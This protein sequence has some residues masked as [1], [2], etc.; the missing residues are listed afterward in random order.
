MVH[1]RNIWYLYQQLR[2]EPTRRAVRIHGSLFLLHRVLPTLYH[3][4]VILY[5]VVTAHSVGLRPIPTWASESISTVYLDGWS[6]V[7]LFDRLVHL[8]SVYPIFRLMGGGVDALYRFVYSVL[9][10]PSLTFY[11]LSRPMHYPWRRDFRYLMHTPMDVRLYGNLDLERLRRSVRYKPFPHHQYMIRRR[12]GL[13]VVRRRRLPR[14]RP[15][16]TKYAE[17][18]V[19]PPTREPRSD[20]PTDPQDDEPEFV[21]R[22]PSSEPWF[23]HHGFDF[24]DGLDAYRRATMNYENEVHNPLQPAY[25]AFENYYGC[26]SSDAWD[27]ITTYS[28]DPLD[29]FLKEKS[30]L[31]ADMFRTTSEDVVLKRAFIA[32]KQLLVDSSTAR[33]QHGIFL[34]DQSK[35]DLLDRHLDVPIVIDTGASFSLTPFMSDFTSP[36]EPPDV[37]SLTGLTDKVDVKGVG[38]VEWT[39]RD[40]NG[41]VALIRTRAYYVPKADIRLMSPQTYFDIHEGGSAVLDRH[42]MTLNTPDDVH[43]DFPYHPTSNLPLLWPKEDVPVGGFHQ[44]TKLHLMRFFNLTKSRSLIVP[45]NSNLNTKERE[46]L[47]WHYRLC[48]ASLGWIQALMRPVKMAQEEAQPPIV[49][50]SCQGTRNVDHP[51]CSACL[52]AKQHR[53][54]AKSQ[55]VQQK[56]DRQLAIRRQSLAPGDEVSADQFVCRVPG[57]LAHTKGKESTADMYHGGTIWVDHYS[58]YIHLSL[59]VSLR[60]G[61]TLVGKRSFERSA[62][63]LG[64]KIKSYRTDNA[65]FNSKL[66]RSDLDRLGQTIT[67]SGVGAHHQAGVAERAI[68]TITQWARAMMMHQLLHWPEQFNESHWGFAMSQAVFLWNHLP[69]QDTKLSP[70]ELFSSLKL[71]DHNALLRARVWGCPTWVLDPVLQD[72]KKIPKFKPRSRLGV[73]LGYSTDHHSTVNRILNPRTGHVSAQFHTVYDES[74]KTV[75]GELTDQVFDEDL[76]N[77]ILDLDGVENHLDPADLANEDDDDRCPDVVRNAK[78]L[79][80]EFIGADPEVDPSDML[81][82]LDE[83]S[84][85]SS[86]T[87]DSEGEVDPDTFRRHSE[88]SAPEG[89]ASSVEPDPE[90][91]LP[92]SK[93]GR[94]IKPVDRLMYNV[95][96]PSR[97][98][99]IKTATKHRRQY[100]RHVQECYSA[101]G[102]TRKKVR[103]SGLQEENLHGLNWNPLSFLTSGREDTRRAMA[104]LLSLHEDGQSWEPLALAA[105]GDD[106]ENNPTWEQAMNGPLKEGYMEACRKEIE[107]LKAMDVWDV[108]DRESWMNVLPSV[109]AFKRKLYPD[110]SV[111][112]LKSRLCAGGHKQIHGVDY[113]STFAPTVS[114]TTVRLMLILSTQLGL[115]TRQVD[116]TAAFVHAD[117]DKPPNY[118]LLTPEQ[119][120]QNGVFIEMPRGFSEPGKVCKLKK[121]LYGL[122]QGP[123]LWFQ[124]LKSKLENVGFVQATEID[125]CLFISDKVIILVYVDD[126]LLYAKNEADIDEVL[127][128]LVDEQKMTLEVEDSVA[129]F[130]GVHIARDE[131]TGELELTQK[132]LIDRIVEA[133]GATDLPSVETPAIHVLGTDEE[134][135]PASSTFNYASV[136]GM[137]WYVYSHSR[138]DLGY[139]VSSAARFAFN[140]KRSHELALIRIGQYLKGTS[141]RGL[142]LKPIS[143]DKL[144]L[145]VYVDSDF[146]GLYGKERRENPDNVKSR[147]GHVMLLNGCPI[148]WSS[149][150]MHQVALST[151]MAEYY[152]LSA[153][154]KEVLPL[155]EVTKVV[156]RALGI[157]ES[158]ITDFK[159][160][161]WE[162]NMGCLILAQHEPGHNTTR[163]KFYDVRVHWF[164]QILHQEGS[165]MTVEKIASEDQLSDIFTKITKPDTF[166]DLRA[167]L[168]GW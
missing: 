154:M 74:F 97:P 139:S 28:V 51:K 117:I 42:G 80:N 110:G 73:N 79:F 109:W 164:R 160:T 108:V 13:H 60:V 146:M 106:P 90:P 168:M 157:D 94:P 62:S 14:S 26:T 31:Y 129:G 33:A 82:D 107:T 25:T 16:K 126:T 134:G 148:I 122:A 39:V 65:P 46:L 141:R 57:R 162:D 4:F 131:K 50:T 155:L 55:T 5:L 118:D 53:T 58:Q 27:Y 23:D 124:F 104:H 45:E 86:S 159:T 93:S 149:K 35:A 19:A 127:T 69:R 34:T 6:T 167:R 43:L 89:D 22:P 120:S 2:P 49:P 105:K 70:I 18:E 63:D 130:L 47:L 67:Y 68:Q 147:A 153:A 121:S 150:L 100:H 140:P 143:T 87:S 30:L 20:S 99:H 132:G 11:F 64:V 21:P 84:T 88:S 12:L 102:R 142:R 32:A 38:W 91:E 37:D 145:D 1:V 59:Q 166:R 96:T 92:R 85:S 41:Q 138:P 81:P 156:A 44:H 98:H 151:M 152:A 119:Q 165:Q 3:V 78:D 95:M 15:S 114:W 101:G 83:V 77:A 112:K 17:P 24:V 36:I 116:Y 133:V 144:R 48:H 123:R 163:S 72:G 115:A 29:M 54:S 103:C 71:R 9:L 40:S 125:P 137:L 128:K 136:I 113:W 10:L 161:V 52:L 111:R 7:A 135:D 76:W 61:E 66:F 56:T 158:V 8:A 75:Y